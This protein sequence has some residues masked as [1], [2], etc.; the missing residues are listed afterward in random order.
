MLFL[1]FTGTP[2]LYAENGPQDKVQAQ[3]KKIQRLKIGI[4]GQRERIKGAREQ[5]S[6]LLAELEKLNQ[7]LLSGKTRLEELKLKLAEQEKRI[8]EKQKEEEQAQAEKEGA[9]VHVK[10]RLN[11]YYR[12]GPIGVMN[13]IFS[14]SELPDLLT[15]REYFDYLLKYDQEV[16]S[17]YREKIAGLNAVQEALKAEKKELLA[18]ITKVKEQEIKL[19]KTKEDRLRLLSR[20]QTEKRLY[21]RALEELEEAAKKL[22]GTL[23]QL[24]AEAGEQ[25][26]KKVKRRIISKKKRPKSFGFAGQ[27]GKLDPPVRGTVT[28]R[29][30]KNTKGKFGITTFANGIDIKA[31]PGTKIRAVYDG[32]VVFSGFL[33]GY[34]NLLIIDHGQQYYSLISRAE[35]FYKKEGDPVSTGEIIGLMSGRQGLLAEGLHF[36]IRKGTAPEN[37]LHW[38]N[39]AKLKI[40]ATR[41]TAN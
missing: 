11:A 4:E 13:V 10:K 31:P 18:V 23:A 39:N 33:R 22:G 37:P 7:Q 1:F 5:E 40:M 32:K 8:Q 28:T 24:K 2:Q 14:T 41:D 19:A 36:E 12:M 25:S 20:V 3:E 26:R 27:R 34:G 35:T 30:G 38:V 6:G 16:I 17:M 15:F 29:F 21:H 9:K